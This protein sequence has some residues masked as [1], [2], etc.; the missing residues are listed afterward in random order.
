[1]AAA[2]FGVPA[3]AVGLPRHRGVLADGGKGDVVGL[4]ALGGERIVFFPAHARPGVQY[5]LQKR[6]SVDRVLGD[7]LRRALGGHGAAFLAGF[8]TDVDDPIGRLDHVEI[9]LHDDHR[10]AQID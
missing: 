4:L 1:M 5:R 10:V 3:T 2:Q 6:S 8:G 9:M 7:L